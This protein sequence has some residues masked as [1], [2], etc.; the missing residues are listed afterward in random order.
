MY[1][2]KYY[3]SAASTLV[4]TSTMAGVGQRKCPTSNSLLHAVITLHSKEIYGIEVKKLLLELMVHA[5]QVQE[6][7][8]V[9]NKVINNKFIVFVFINFFL[10]PVN[11]AYP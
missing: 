1:S 10:K 6:C 9:M 2:F 7:R 11:L 4:L 8:V 5:C 3:L